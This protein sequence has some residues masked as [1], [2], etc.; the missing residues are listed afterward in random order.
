[1]REEDRSETY[2]IKRIDDPQ[3][4]LVYLKK[5]LLVII[6]LVLLFSVFISPVF[7]NLTD[8]S[9]QEQRPTVKVGIYDDYPVVYSK[10]GKAKGIYVEIL[11]KV[12]KEENWK[13]EYIN[14]NWERSLQLLENGSIDIMTGIAYSQE[15][16]DRF[17]FSKETVLSNW[18]QVYIQQNSN[19]E[20]FE[21][22]ESKKIAGM[23]GDVYYEGEKG[24]KNLLERFNINATFVEY[25]ENSQVLKAIENGSADAGVVTRLYG[26]RKESSF[27][28]EKSPIIFSPTELRFAFPK[29]SDS[30]HLM[31][32]IDENLREM[33]KNPDSTYYRALEQYLSSGS[34]EGGGQK[35]VMPIWAEQLLFI[36]GILLGFLALISVIFRRQLKKKTEE[37]GKI[38]IRL[39]EHIREK[40]EAEK[41]EEFFH[42]LLRQDLRSKTQLSLGYLNLLEEHLDKKELSEEERE[43]LEKAKDNTLD[44]LNLIHQVKQ[45]RAVEN[46]EGR[47]KIK[48]QKVIGDALEDN[49]NLLKRKNV[50]IKLEEDDPIIEG[51]YYLSDLFSNFIRMRASDKSCN[52]IDIRIVEKKKKVFVTMDDDG[53]KFPK[54]MKKDIMNRPYNGRTTGFGGIRFYL[55]RRIADKEDIDIKLKDSSMGG[56]RIEIWLDKPTD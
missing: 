43:V 13:I 24:I 38:N 46:M 49:E 42:T 6:V 31:E 41:R 1:M 50:E 36:G 56:G 25:Q 35:H 53:R 23:E 45:V 19:I 30:D 9:N 47:G 8:G 39:N 28:V 20:S 10:D 37:L 17:K 40:E 51:N 54:D 11:E 18:G 15:R 26:E 33:K 3:Q 32:R 14:Q 55:A 22:L 34:D 12:A 52:M 5:P 29:N 2:P 21:D 16:T 7:C 44:G 27:S 48:L 4:R